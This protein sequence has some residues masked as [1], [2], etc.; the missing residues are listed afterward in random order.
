[1]KH[2][3]FSRL[4]FL[5]S[6]YNEAFFLELKME[7]HDDTASVK[8]FRSTSTMGLLADQLDRLLEDN[9]SENDAIIEDFDAEIKDLLDTDHDVEM[10]ASEQ[11]MEET[12]LDTPDPVKPVYFG[13]PSVDYR[14]K[15]TGKPNLPSIEKKP[16]NS[17]SNPFLKPAPST[18][19]LSSASENSNFV[20]IDPET[21]S[22][23][24]TVCEEIEVR[25]QSSGGK[26]QQ[27]KPDNPNPFKRPLKP[28][29]KPILSQS[30]KKS[31]AASIVVEKKIK[32]AE[33]KGKTFHPGMCSNS[34][35]KAA[36]YRRDGRYQGNRA[37]RYKIALDYYGITDEMIQKANEEYWREK[38]R[39]GVPTAKPAWMQ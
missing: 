26:T 30:I 37:N 17:K 29:G 20:I 18:K 28:A 1:M 13:F 33:A 25:Q 39:K 7:H 11:D 31:I 22:L 36:F 24:E 14:L 32:T 2:F 15:S 38:E 12:L 19:L 4:G 34:D 5:G 23:P 6:I 3:Y 9:P 27:K 21:A 8:S 35:E 10:T 16:V